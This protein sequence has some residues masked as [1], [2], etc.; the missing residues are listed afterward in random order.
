MERVSDNKA[1]PG[2]SEGPKAGTGPELQQLHP[3]SLNPPSLPVSHLS[4]SQKTC[5]RADT[6]G[7]GVPELTGPSCLPCTEWFIL[8]CA[9][10]MIWKPQPE[11]RA[12]GKGLKVNYVGLGSSEALLAPLLLFCARSRGSTRTPETQCVSL[13]SGL[14]SPTLLS[15]ESGGTQHTE[16]CHPPGLGRGWNAIPISES[17]SSSSQVE[18]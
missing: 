8:G 4:F 1:P 12:G 13:A 16:C 15:L 6:R 5:A 18:L 17:S 14:G 9:K 7:G 3:S 10:G 11:P 2:G